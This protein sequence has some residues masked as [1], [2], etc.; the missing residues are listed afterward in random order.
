MPGLFR[1][2]ARKDDK[3]WI[4]IKPDQFDT[5]FFFSVNL[6]RGIGETVAFSAA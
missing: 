1:T 6:S 2:L 4:E 5:P 3:V